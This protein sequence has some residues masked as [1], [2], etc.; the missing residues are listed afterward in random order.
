MGLVRAVPGGRVVD[1]G[2][3]TGELTAE[4]HRHVGASET[5]GIDSSAAMLDKAAAHAGGGVRFEQGD[6]ATWAPDEPVDVVFANASLHWA[7]DHP[8]VLAAW[9]AALRPAGQ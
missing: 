3:G 1:L 9:V 2:C 4:L 8:R 5:V 7:P 6:L